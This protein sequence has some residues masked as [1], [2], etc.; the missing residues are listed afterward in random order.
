[1]TT[2]R[3]SSAPPRRN[4][5]TSP[6]RTSGRVPMEVREARRRKRHRQVIRNRIIFGAACL[7]ILALIITLVVRLISALVN[8]NKPVETSTLT[9]DKDGS[10]VFEEIAEFDSELYS[11]KDLK[12]F[13]R[14]EIEEYNE[15]AADDKITLEKIKIKNDKC[16][17]K[18]GYS[19]ADIYADYTD[20]AT[21]FGTIEEAYADGYTFDGKFAE[22]SEGIKGQLLSTDIQNDYAGC[23]VA[24]VNENCDIVVPGNIVCISDESTSVTDANSVRISQAD[25]NPD[26]TNTVYIIFSIKE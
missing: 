2:R 12:R 7:A 10:V 24:V 13:V 4:V 9:F 23:Y 8:S 22:V 21:Y 14:S 20:Y 1:M 18:T 3:T 16:Y 25:G 26:A 15:K 19:T 6:K 17:I 11:E 5:R